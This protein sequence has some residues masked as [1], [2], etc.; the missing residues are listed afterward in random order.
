MKVSRRNFIKN[1]SVSA[2]G[3]GLLI[4]DSSNILGQ[5]FV[6]KSITDTDLLSSLK[7]DSFNSFIGE[8]FTFYTEEIAVQS[9]LSEVVILTSKKPKM[10]SRFSNRKSNISDC[11]LLRFEVQTSDLKQAT[12][13]VY[14]KSLGQFDLLLVPGESVSGTQTLSGIINRI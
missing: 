2:I 4:A 14:Q 8:D 9:V 3:A 6:S 12:Y 7:A 13:R 10:N 1:C 11:F 5:N